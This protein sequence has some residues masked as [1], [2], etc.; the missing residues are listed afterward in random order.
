[1]S[2]SVPKPTKQG[3]PGWEPWMRN[4]TKLQGE[5]KWHLT[6]YTNDSRI[7]FTGPITEEASQRLFQDLVKTA[8]K[9]GETRGF[10]PKVKP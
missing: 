8:R 10:V 1:M 9:Y 3:D 2:D 7:E 4:L 5:A 6:I